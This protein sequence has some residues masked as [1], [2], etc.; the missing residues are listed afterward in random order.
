LNDRRL[1]YQG[2]LQSLQH[3]LVERSRAMSG[4]S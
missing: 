2:A 4:Q 3:A 1:F